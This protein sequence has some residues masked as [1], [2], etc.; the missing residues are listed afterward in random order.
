[1][2]KKFIID[3]NLVTGIANYLAT[4]PYKEVA[5]AIGAL[6]QLQEYKEAITKK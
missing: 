3:E 2:S 4:R 1:M 6:Q 5:E